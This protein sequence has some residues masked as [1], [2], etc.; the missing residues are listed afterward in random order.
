M[1]TAEATTDVAATEAAAHM[2]TAEATTHVAAAPSAARESAGGWK[3][4][5]CCKD[6]DEGEFLVHDVHPSI[7]GCRPD[8][9][10]GARWPV[11]AGITRC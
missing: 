1:T 6:C 7:R 10:L 2:T 11:G 3:R 5:C 8:S 4:E 9:H